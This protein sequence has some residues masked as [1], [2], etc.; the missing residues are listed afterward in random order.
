M[1]YDPN[2]NLVLNQI[3]DPFQPDANGNRPAYQ[4]NMVPQNEW[5][6]VGQA[7]LNLYP[8][9]N[10]A[11]VKPKSLFIVSAANPAFT[12]SR[13]LAMTSERGW[14]GCSAW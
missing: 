12:R 3:F 10:T 5:D 9:P 11:G 8:K 14:F 1:T 6:K 2:G 7:I 4:N 13:K